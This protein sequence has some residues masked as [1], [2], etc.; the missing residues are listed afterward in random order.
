[1]QSTLIGKGAC[2][3]F[4]YRRFC[5]LAFGRSFIDL[6]LAGH[7]TL[8]GAAYSGVPGRSH[9]ERCGSSPLVF[10][11]LLA[12]Y[13]AMIT[14]AILMPLFA[15]ALN[16]TQAEFYYHTAISSF[17]V[18]DIIIIIFSQIYCT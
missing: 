15:R 5:S 10:F 16:S 9:G 6:W 8:L 11:F 2:L 3:R 4:Y 18:I 17:S 1:M 13:A 12:A 7:D 14:V